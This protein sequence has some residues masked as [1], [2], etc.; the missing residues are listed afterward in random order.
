MYLWVKWNKYLMFVL[1]CFRVY[2]FVYVK[3]KFMILYD[4]IN[5][6]LFKKIKIILVDYG[7]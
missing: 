7:V 4:F 5:L 6:L 1:F 2:F 3:K